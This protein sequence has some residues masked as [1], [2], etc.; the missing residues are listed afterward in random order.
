MRNKFALVF[1][2]ISMTQFAQSKTEFEGE[3]VKISFGK[4]IDS[5]KT[6]IKFTQGTW[7]V[8]LYSLF[9]NNQIVEN[10]FP[11][12]AGI[13]KL[14]INYSNDLY[15]SEIVLYRITPKLE[16]LSLNF[17]QDSGKI[18]CRIKSEYAQELNKE[19]VLNKF[20]DEIQQIINSIKE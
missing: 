11:K 4:N 18:F 14:I 3:Q 1:I 13:Y 5:K 16:K 12:E 20:T 2:L 7:N 9:E 6:S 17:Y 19:I 15:Y 8:T 10:S